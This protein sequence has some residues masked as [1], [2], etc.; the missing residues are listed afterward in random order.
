M[1]STLVDVVTWLYYIMFGLLMI[2]VLLSWMPMIHGGGLAGFIF[3]FTEPILAPVRRLV[4]RSP[5]G[6]PGMMFDLSILVAF[7]LL[8]LLRIFLNEILML[9]FFSII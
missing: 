3:A 2:R 4:D 8:R 7:I 1:Y 5:I 9:V 6:G